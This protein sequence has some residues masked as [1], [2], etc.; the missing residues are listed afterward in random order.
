MLRYLST[1]GQTK[2][3]MFFTKETHM[4]DKPK[5]IIEIVSDVV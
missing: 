1:N 2:D 5:L 3:R 4:S